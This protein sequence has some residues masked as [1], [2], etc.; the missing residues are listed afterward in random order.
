MKQHPLSQLPLA[1]VAEALYVA[2]DDV[3][4]EITNHRVDGR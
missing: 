2:V 1:Q 3:G 4:N